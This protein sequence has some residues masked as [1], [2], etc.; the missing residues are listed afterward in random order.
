MTVFTIK[1]TRVP[2][3]GQAEKVWREF[4]DATENAAKMLEPAGTAVASPWHDYWLPA[5][6]WRLRA[7]LEN[8]PTD[9]TAEFVVQ[10]GALMI[11]LRKPL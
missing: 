1:T 4:C 10:D 9:T 2:V 11:E 6:A 3:T 5:C 7:V 8:A